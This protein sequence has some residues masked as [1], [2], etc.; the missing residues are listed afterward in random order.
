MHRWT[1]FVS[2]ALSN[3]NCM[4]VRVTR[5]VGY[6]CANFSLPVT[7]CSRLRP[8]VRDR[9]QTDVRRQTA[10][11]LNASALWGRRHNNNNNNRI[12][13]APYGRNFTGAGGRSD[14]CSVNAWVN[15]NVLSPRLKIDRESLTKTVCG[16]FWHAVALRQLLDFIFQ[17]QFIL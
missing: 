2:A 7:L 4:Y 12:C 11:S 9:H 14:Q 3:S 5:D 13:I 10:S 1:L 15:K 16:K 17:L 6:L 8:D